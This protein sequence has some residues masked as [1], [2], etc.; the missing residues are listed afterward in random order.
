VDIIHN[1]LSSLEAME[2][3]D[4]KWLPN[5]GGAYKKI[6]SCTNRH[7]PNLQPKLRMGGFMH[8][9]LPVPS[10]HVTGKTLDFTSTSKVYVMDLGRLLS[11]LNKCV[12]N[13]YLT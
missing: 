13:T 1:L 8:V 2:F 3:V 12:N 7:H 11:K 10:W 4:K 5:E 9:L 6:W